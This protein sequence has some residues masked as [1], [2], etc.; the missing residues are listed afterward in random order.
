MTLLHINKCCKETK[1]HKRDDFV[2][3]NAQRISLKIH[4]MVVI[5]MNVQKLLIIVDKT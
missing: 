2:M 1:I 3:Q 5:L 4:I